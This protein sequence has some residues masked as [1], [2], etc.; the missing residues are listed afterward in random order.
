MP[1]DIVRNGCGKAANILADSI[2]NSV[3]IVRDICLDG[4]LTLAH[5]IGHLQGARHNI[6]ADPITTPFAY[7]HGYLDGNVRQRTI[8]GVNN[9]AICDPTNGGFTCSRQPLWSDPN[10]DFPASIAPAGIEATNFNAKVLFSTAQYISSLRGDVQRF[11]DTEPQG[12][13]EWIGEQINRIFNQGDTISVTARFDEAIHDE[14][15]PHVTITDNVVSITA[16]MTKSTETVYTYSHILTDEVGDVTLSFS[17]ARD[18]FGNEIIL[19]PTSGGTIN[20]IIPDTEL[21]IINLIGD[22][23]QTIDVNTSYTELGATATDNVDATTTITSQIVIDSSAGNDAV[24]GEYLVKYDVMDSAGN[25]A[26][27][28]TRTVTVVEPV[29]IPDPPTGLTLNT[30]SYNQIDLTWIEPDNGGSDITGYKIERELVDESGMGTGYVTINE[31]TENQLIV[32]EDTFG[33]LPDTTYNY[34][35]SA[36]NALGVGTPSDE[37]TVMTLP[38]IQ[39]THSIELSQPN[40]SYGFKLAFLSSDKFLVSGIG[41]YTI[42]EP[43]YDVIDLFDVNCTL[44]QTFPDPDQFGFEGFGKQIIPISNDKFLTGARGDDDFG[45]NSGAVYLFHINGTLLDKIYHPSPAAED[46]FGQYI[47]VIGTDKFLVASPRD[48]DNVGS[49]HLFSI[50]GT[51]LKTIPNPNPNPFE[52]FGSSIVSVGN[53]KFLANV[54]GDTFWSG[55]DGFVYLF[56]IDGNLIQTITDPIPDTLDAFGSIISLVGSDTLLISNIGSLL[57]PAIDDTIH[58]FDLNDNSTKILNTP[59]VNAPSNLNFATLSSGSLGDDKFL[60]NLI[61]D[62][63]DGT[64]SGAVHIFDINKNLLGTIVNTS[65]SNDSYSL[66]VG[67]AVLDDDEFLIK[68]QSSDVIHFFKTN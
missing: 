9:D 31:N 20:V 48:D 25:D 30:I 10:Q 5:E 8:M 50:N 62:N 51:W 23:P 43:N 28:V 42:P 66:N 37:I 35:V 36:I 17:N 33:L 64:F 22:N 47:A 57:G 19:T 15:P 39:S 52:Y 3:A 53:D 12:F 45:S 56:D 4:N 54:P 26:E 68:F 6:E 65:S 11:D 7:G 14:F 49:V 40:N 67:V 55:S 60:V 2:E 63:A 27:Q 61:L 24:I 29:T 1:A 41:N 44:I 34:R 59:V 16:E 32:Y 13:F 38:L 46:Y 21:P 58:I 18:L